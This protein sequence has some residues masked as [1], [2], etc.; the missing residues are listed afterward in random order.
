MNNNSKLLIGV[1]AI[2]IIAF[3]LNAGFGITGKVTEVPPEEEPASLVDRIRGLFGF[4]D[5]TEDLYYVEPPPEEL[6]PEEPLYVEDDIMVSIDDRCL[7]IEKTILACEDAYYS[8]MGSATKSFYSEQTAAV[9]TCMT[10]RDCSGIE[11]GTTACVKCCYFAT[12]TP[13][14][15]FV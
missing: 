7:A 6:P 1:L 8:C 12:D 13:E 14:D 2:I 11:A 3:I 4:G 15:S 10:G 5:E 9:C